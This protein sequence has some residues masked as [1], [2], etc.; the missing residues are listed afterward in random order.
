MEEET[1]QKN[2]SDYIPVGDNFKPTRYGRKSGRKRKPKS[3]HRVHTGFSISRESLE[4]LKK[5]IVKS[6]WSIFIDSLIQNWILLSKKNLQ[7]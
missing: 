2:P 5:N 7:G 3:K 1:K 4:F 6:K